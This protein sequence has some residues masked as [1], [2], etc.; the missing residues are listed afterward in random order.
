MSAL[1]LAFM[2]TPDFAVPSLDALLS[3]GHDVVAVYC[4]PPRPAGR[5][6]KL[7]PCPVQ[8]FAEDRGL[9]VHS[10]A[11]LRD[12]DVQ[13]AFRNLQLDAA[14]VTAYGLILPPAI[15][16]APRLGCLNVHASL[17]PRW[18]GAAPIQRAILE[19]D[20]R[21]GITIMQMD[22]G[23]DT[24]AMLLQEATAIT[25]QD[26]GQRLHDRLTLMGGAMVA[27]ALEGL[28]QGK[29]AAVPQPTT[30]I[31]YA[32]K[33]TREEAK[34]D[35]RQDAARLERQVR[36]FTPWPGAWFE[37]RGERL[38]VLE[39]EVIGRQEPAAPGTLLDQRLT[40]ACGTQALRITRLQRAGKAPMAAADFL[41][42][43]RLEAGDLL[44]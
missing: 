33:L 1:K 29:L 31:T 36:A 27:Q 15:L 26:T 21:S 22:E 44:T 35:W 2:G 8:V 3:A 24:G 43:F 6:K 17:L 7:R 37:A 10:P 20:Y 23:L 39:A 16:Q 34:L 40:V 18:R 28:Q 9:T 30:G 14:V 12:V 4:Q 13:N 42:G 19:G 5:G 41:R 32:E 38:R 11:S 25:A